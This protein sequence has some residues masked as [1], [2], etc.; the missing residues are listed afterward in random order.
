MVCENDNSLGVGHAYS[1]TVSVFAEQFQRFLLTQ[2]Q[3]TSAISIIG[4]LS[5]RSPGISSSIWILDSGASHHMSP[6]FNSFVPLH[7]AP[8]VPIMTADGTPMSIAGTGSVSTS[9]LSISDV[10]YIPKLRESN[11]C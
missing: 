10:Y 6:N 3:A 5:S 11:F 7:P 4:L 2:P 9:H 8:S 1:P